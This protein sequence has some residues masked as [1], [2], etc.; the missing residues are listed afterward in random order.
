M[1]GI[2]LPIPRMRQALF[3]LIESAILVATLLAAVTSRFAG[4]VDLVSGDRLLVPKIL[5][6]T[7]ILQL[8]L[9]YSELYDDRAN[10]AATD[11]HDFDG[12]M[13]PANRVF[14][15]EGRQLKYGERDLWGCVA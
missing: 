4:N 13:A 9:Y 3:L 1:A 14:L 7:F 12:Q 8:C 2:Y 11:D 15:L 5:L 6:T 10:E